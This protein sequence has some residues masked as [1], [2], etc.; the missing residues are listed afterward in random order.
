MKRLAVLTVVLAFLV[1]GCANP[2]TN[3][4][5][6][7]NNATTNAN[8]T[9][10][11][12][13]ATATTTPAGAAQ[14]DIIN[15]ERQVIDAVRR[16]DHNAFA[17]YLA[18]DHIYVTADRVHDRAHS[19]EAIKS[20]EVNELTASDYKVLNIDQDA[21]VVYYTINFK[22]SMQGKP[23]PPETARASTAW[24]KRDGKWVA[25]YHQECDIE[26]PPANQPPQADKKQ[27]PQQ[28][29][30]TSASPASAGGGD[31]ATSREKQLWEVLKRGDYDGFAGLLS[32]DSVSVEPYGVM[33]KATLLSNLR[34]LNFSG[35]SASEFKE[36]KLDEDAALVTYVT[37][38]PQP[39]FS[40]NGERHTTIWAKRNGRWQAVFH[41]WTTIRKS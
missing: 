20:V 24:V 3:Q 22:G 17:G 18:D 32:D 41:H 35:A 5:A 10:N 37:R 1:A 31:D 15:Q 16:N 40:P 2:N 29:P 14:E 19:I 8:A 12:N 21:A 39:T 6:G 38:G 34:Q 28:S 9:A 11:T 7:S 36:M 13:A 23:L 33:D 27:S 26:Q 4:G 30:A 25:A